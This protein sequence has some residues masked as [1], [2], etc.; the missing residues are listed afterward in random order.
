[1]TR[2]GDVMMPEMIIA[3]TRALLKKKGPATHFTSRLLDAVTG[4][5]RRGNR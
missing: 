4:H 2:Y 5:W 1:M 3:D